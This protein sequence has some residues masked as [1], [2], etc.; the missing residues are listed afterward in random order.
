MSSNPIPK[1]ELSLIGN[2]GPAD[3]AAR[4]AIPH[5][6]I[7]IKYLIRTFIKYNASDLHLK[8]GRPP[9]YRIN[10]RLI[11]VKLPDFTP[12]QLEHLI[13]TILTPKQRG[14][15]EHDRELNTTFL[16]PDVGR[17]RCNVYYQLGNLAA[18]IRMIPLV[19]PKIDDLGLPTVL[20]DIAQRP[21]GLFLVTGASGTGK[22]TTL[23]AMIQYINENSH[24]HIL[25][26]EDPIEFLFRDIKA[27]ITQRQVG[28]DTLS[29]Q[30]GLA[31]GLRQDPDVIVIG[32]LLDRDMI[33]TALTAA[34]TGHLVFATL[35]TNTAK[36]SISR[37][38]DVFPPEMRPQV[39][40][41]LAST[42]IGVISQQLLLRTDASGRIA[43]C[44]VMVKSPLIEEF[45]RNDQTDRIPEAIEN[46]NNHYR[47]QTMNQ[48]LQLLVT[49]KA[50]TLDEA[51]KSS[52]SPDNLRLALSGMNR[53]SG[54]EMASSDQP[55][56]LMPPP[57][58][59]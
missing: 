31:S 30:D 9:L 3:H 22:S 27:S 52:D 59:S 36:S 47:M 42:L 38:I 1:P 20:K 44:E 39:R 34:E 54:Y 43:A 32:E 57:L 29:F 23:A 17:F 56:S 15:L 55:S 2:P 13:S 33:Q 12:E 45:I 53:E 5:S 37:I 41:Q 11:P 25:S 4:P 21:R 46:S 6:K 40:I 8:V 10:G 14:D 48:A 58:K 24:V 19:V 16:I 50:V 49:S 35:H 18:A 28:I 51:L 26:L 7:D